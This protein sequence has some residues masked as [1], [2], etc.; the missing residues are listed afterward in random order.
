[1]A[2]APVAMPHERPSMHY[3]VI[4]STLPSPQPGTMSPDCSASV[5]AEPQH[6]LCLPHLLVLALKS[7]ETM[8]PGGMDA[9]YPS[10]TCQWNRTMQR[11]ALPAAHNADGSGSCTGLVNAALVPQMSV[12][13]VDA[14]GSGL[15]AIKWPAT[16]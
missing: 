12:G 14:L 15:L 2:V 6:P 13:V 9:P 8:P 3:R 5:A 16:G 7:P 11:A 10:S 1:M 4:A